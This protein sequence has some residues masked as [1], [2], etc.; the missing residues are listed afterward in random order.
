MK[1]TPS[2]ENA[3]RIKHTEP[4]HT[5]LNLNFLFRKEASVDAYK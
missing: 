3:R 5:T 4:K 2:G 1:K